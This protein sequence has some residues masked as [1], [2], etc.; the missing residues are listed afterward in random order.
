MLCTDQTARHAI[1]TCLLGGSKCMVPQCGSLT[2]FKKDSE[3]WA[4]GLD[5]VYK[6]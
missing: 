1:A 4:L 3:V 2:F 6:G 5:R